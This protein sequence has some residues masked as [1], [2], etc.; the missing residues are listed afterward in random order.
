MTIEQ[1]YF[2][3]PPEPRFLSELGDLAAR[4]DNF[5]VGVRDLWGKG[6][7]VGGRENDLKARV[8]NLF[9]VA[10]G[11]S[12]KK[13]VV[14]DFFKSRSMGGA[15]ARLW[16]RLLKLHPG[17]GSNRQI[18]EE[19]ILPEVK[20]ALGGESSAAV[21]KVEEVLGVIRIANRDEAGGDSVRQPTPGGK[22]WQPAPR[23]ASGLP[24][25]GDS[26]EPGDDRRKRKKAEEARKKLERAR[27]RP[28]DESR[29][30]MKRESMRGP[31]ITLTAVALAVA[32]CVAPRESF[33]KKAVGLIP[34]AMAW[35]VDVGEWMFS[36]EQWREHEV[37]QMAGGGGLRWAAGEEQKPVLLRSFETSRKAIVNVLTGQMLDNDLEDQLEGYDMVKGDPERAKA[38]VLGWD[39]GIQDIMGPTGEVNDDRVRTPDE[40]QTIRLKLL[41]SLE[42]AGYRGVE[43]E[44]QVDEFIY[45]LEQ[46]NG[47]PIYWYEGNKDADGVGILGF[48]SQRNLVQGYGRSVKSSAR[49]FHRR[50]IRRG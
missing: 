24:D 17:A 18:I 41:G 44:G 31:L 27:R 20:A 26:G 32:Y 12:E 19:E 25:M 42:Q 4:W 48:P 43:I 23:E 37:E 21:E 34:R 50:M 35:G 15:E 36:P 10:K 16:G 30:Q 29:E 1:A 11:L 49:Q 7:L 6:G 13:E 46:V 8:E 5:M 45:L 9:D 33:M 2:N 3:N 22:K 40:L 28:E 14:E 38:K 47:F 39:Q